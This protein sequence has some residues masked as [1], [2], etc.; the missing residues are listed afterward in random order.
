MGALSAYL[1]TPSILQLED[2][3][4]HAKTH[5]HRT[6]ATKRPSS[7]KLK[8]KLMLKLLLPIKFGYGYSRSRCTFLVVGYNFV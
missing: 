6:T 1:Q 2:A 7:P 4:E 8:L 3:S 5:A